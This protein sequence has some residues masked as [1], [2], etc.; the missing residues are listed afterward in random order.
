MDYAQACPRY[1]EAIAILGK[2]WTGL[3]L[4]LLMDGPK[5][6]TDF[7]SHIPGLNDR[8]LSDRLREL[9]EAG[10]LVREVHDTKPVLIE[11]RLTEKGRAL[12]PVVKAI[13]AWAED[14][15]GR[16]RSPSRLAREEQAASL[17]NGR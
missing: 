12:E 4:R 8:S 5:R 1:E 17:S 16:Q 6:F 7:K 15:C 10:V 9:E 2:K 13:Q 14:W 3:I 11:Y